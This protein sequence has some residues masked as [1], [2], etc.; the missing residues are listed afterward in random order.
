MDIRQQ[1]VTGVVPPEIAEARVREVWPSVA[2][3]PAIAALGLKLTNTIILAPLG[4]LIMSLT[5]FAKL[6][7]FTMRRYALTN[8]RLMIRSGWAAAPSKEIALDKI[9]DVKL[10]RDGNTEFFR[11]A[12][13]D[14]ISGG[15]T[16]MTLPGVPDPEGFR[17]AILHTRNAW[18]PA[19]AK[20][21]PFL[22]ASSVK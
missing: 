11:A 7:P 3:A 1:A 9:D 12:N 15:Q 18:V 10:I 4:W 19:K 6:L 20:T 13:L 22:P 14:I 16:V 8:R 2:S 5:Y 21:Q 17:H